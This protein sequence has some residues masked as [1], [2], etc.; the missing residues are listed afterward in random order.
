[1]KAPH[2]KPWKLLLAV[3]S[4]LAFV[5]AA[6]GDDDS[7]SDSSADPPSD[8]P[9][10]IIGSQQFGESEILAQI[11]GQALADAGYPVEYQ[12]LGGYRDIVFSSFDSGQINF[13]AEYAASALEF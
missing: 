7:D 3:L 1:M 9:T 5:A 10:I 4:V 8:G 11:Y 13:T 12:A 2:S 6:C